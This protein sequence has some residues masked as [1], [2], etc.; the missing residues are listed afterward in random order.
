MIESSFG[1]KDAHPVITAPVD[2]VAVGAEFPSRAALREAG[3]HAPLVGGISGGQDGADSIVVSGGYEDDL[4][5]GDEIIYTGQGGNDHQH[6]QAGRRSGMDSRQ[7]RPRAQ[8]VSRDSRSEWFGVNTAEAFSPRRRGYR[9]DGGLLRP[10]SL[11]G[12]REKWFPDL[13][14]QAG[15]GRTPNP[16]PWGPWERGKATL[17]CASPA[18][19][20]PADHQKT[21]PW[22]PGSR[23]YTTTPARYVAF[24]LRPQEVHTQ[25]VLTSAALGSPHNGPDAEGNL[26]C[27]CPNHH[28]LFDNGALLIK[29]DLTFEGHPGALQTVPGHHV[30]KDQLAYHRGPLEVEPPLDG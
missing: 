2:G 4:D 21:L 29:D 22:Q 24:A 1:D 9:Y 5:R 19:N 20:Y 26:L 30:G 11:A 23:N 14:L 17:A 7:C 6:R 10:G 25:R 15:S 16:R 13:P 18:V 12:D 27:L 28:V 8:A 3:V